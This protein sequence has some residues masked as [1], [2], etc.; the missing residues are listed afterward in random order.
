MA[1]TK[2]KHLIV[3]DVDGVAV[4]DFI[5]SQLMF[6][7]SNVEEIGIELNSLI[8]DHG[9]SKI[10]LDFRNVQYL[11][12]TMLAKLASL[13]RHIEI[14]KGRLTLCGL[15]PILMDTF[16]IGH[17]ERVFSIYDD[18]ESAIRSF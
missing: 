12:S 4:V 1:A 15:G 18:V 17:F 10:V 14:A 2:F 3:K 13:E 9:Y 5:N 6:E 7:A 16:R 8:S 11:S